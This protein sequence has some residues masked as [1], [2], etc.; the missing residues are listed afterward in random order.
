MNNYI[1]CIKYVIENVDSSFYYEHKQFDFI[2]QFNNMLYCA[3]LMAG[4]LQTFNPSILNGSHDEYINYEIQK[5]IVDSLAQSKQNFDFNINY[6][7]SKEETYLIHFEIKKIAVKQIIDF[8]RDFKLGYTRFDRYYNKFLSAIQFAG[9]NGIA[10]SNIFSIS[11]RLTPEE[12]KEVL[13]KLVSDGKI[14]EKTEGTSKKKTYKY[15]FINNN[16][17]TTTKYFK[18]VEE[19]DKAIPITVFKP[20]TIRSIYEVFIEFIQNNLA[21]ILN[22]NSNDLIMKL[23][24]DE[25]VLSYFLRIS[26]VE[27]SISNNINNINNLTNNLVKTFLKADDWSNYHMFLKMQNNSIVKISHQSHSKFSGDADVFEG[28]YENIYIG[29][30]NFLET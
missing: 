25:E 17:T 13:R 14:E 30:E 20:K 18:T 11:R 7:Y 4:E 27:N 24:N 8:T 2:I 3:K 29:I 12:R 26:I 9:D 6:N 16:N 22:E 1:P 19:M 15:Y 10:L 28:Y 5:I 21:N 23:A